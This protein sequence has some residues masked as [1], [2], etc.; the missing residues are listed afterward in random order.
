MGLF[1]VF[2]WRGVAVHLLGTVKAGANWSSGMI[3]VDESS[4]VN[5]MN[6]PN[7]VHM[8]HQD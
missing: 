5:S 4:K 6:E 2:R 8:V 3:I 1:G 7:S